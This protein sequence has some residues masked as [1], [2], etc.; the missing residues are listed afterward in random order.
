MWV[1]SR[2]IQGY[3]AEGKPLQVLVMDTEG[4][5]SLEADA[6]HDLRIFSLALLLSSTFLYNSLGTIDEQALEALQ[7]LLG[8]AKHIQCRAENAFKKRAADADLA[9]F[10]PSSFLWVVRDFALQLEG[11]DGAK[12]SAK[13]YLEKALKLQ[14]GG[15]NDKN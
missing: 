3:T 4:L 7:L 15:A 14:P 13:E 1:W 8:V 11:E 10:L 2:P 6:T 5:A 9:A 12:L